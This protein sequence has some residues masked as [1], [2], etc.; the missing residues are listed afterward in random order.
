MLAVLPFMTPNESAE[1]AGQLVKKL[2]GFD[3]VDSVPTFDSPLDL[4]EAILALY[5]NR[6]QETSFQ[7]DLIALLVAETRKLGFL[8]PPPILF[9][10][11]NW[12]K[13]FFTFLVNPGSGK[14]ELWRTDRLGLIGSP[15]SEWRQWLDGSRK[16]PKWGLLTQPH[17]YRL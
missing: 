2:P 11:T 4:I 17:E 13:Y 1:L 14:L 6:K 15:M 12:P 7:T 8:P 5:I 16:E 9:A 3:P 10:D